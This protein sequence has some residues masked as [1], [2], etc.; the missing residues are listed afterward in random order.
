MTDRGAWLEERRK[1]IGGSD[2]AKVLGISKWGGPLSVFMD[3][4]GRSPEREMTEAMEMGVL[5]EEAVARLFMSRTGF[6]VAR[7]NGILRHPEHPWMLASVD[8]R[9]V[10]HKSGLECKTAH[11]MKAAQ[12]E[13]DGLPDDYYCQTQHYCAVTGW[14]S[15][16]IAALVGGQRFVF[17]EVPRN[18]AFIKEM[19]ARE[20]EFWN[21]YV[22]KDEPPPAGASD[23]VSEIYPEDAT[24]AMLEPEARHTGMLERIFELEGEASRISG[25]IDGLKNRI[26]QD[27]GEAAGIEGIATWKNNR[28]SLRVDWEAVAQELGAT[29]EVISRHTAA[30]PGARVLRLVRKKISQ[31]AA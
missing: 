13:G 2:A 11:F 19:T 17:K 10:G 26:R 18:D 22:A 1:G 31:E 29:P 25:L 14:E 16:W 6:R 23:D 3:K 30:K 24:G 9:I 5:L 4:T 8:R 15:C 7:V 12:W 20:R 28:P 21:E 27:I